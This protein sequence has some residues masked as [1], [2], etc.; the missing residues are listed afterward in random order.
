MFIE[1]GAAKM[2]NELKVLAEQLWHEARRQG[3]V[4][5]CIY[6]SASQNLL[7]EYEL[8]GQSIDAKLTEN[9]DA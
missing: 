3:L 9:R 4:I 1:I 5:D 2:S 7:G 6:F 8:T